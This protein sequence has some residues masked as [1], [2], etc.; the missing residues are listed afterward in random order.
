[1]RVGVAENHD[2]TQ[3]YE[4]IDGLWTMFG[5]KFQD[6][7]EVRTVHRQS[8]SPTSVSTPSTTFYKFQKAPHPDIMNATFPCPSEWK[9][10]EGECV[11]AIKP[12]EK[13]GII[14]AMHACS[15]EV[16]LEAGEGIMNVHWSNLR[17]NVAIGDFA[18]V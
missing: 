18:K 8:V 13:Q 6:G 4:E 9:F 5:H 2:I 16:D 11:V 3:I 7:L 1:M 17:K 15:V 12:L 14:K 10:F